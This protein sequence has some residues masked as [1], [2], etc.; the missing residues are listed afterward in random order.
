MKALIPIVILTGAYF[1]SKRKKDTDT[2]DTNQTQANIDSTDVS[3]DQ[4]I[5]RQVTFI[6]AT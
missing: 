6:K 1:L 3:R 2:T 5:N 4:K